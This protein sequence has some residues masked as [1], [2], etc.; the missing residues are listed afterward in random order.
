MPGD[1]H[2][3]TTRP[4]H[5]RLGPRAR[6]EDF[7]LTLNRTRT[8]TGFEWR[9]RVGDRMVPAIGV[10]TELNEH[11]ADVLPRVLRKAMSEGD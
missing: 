5:T 10:F 8:V 9:L 4:K 6:D 1:E 7:D 11:P 2:Q 3:T